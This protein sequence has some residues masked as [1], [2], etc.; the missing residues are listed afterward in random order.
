MDD[1]IKKGDVMSSIYGIGHSNKPIEVF[2][3]K[4][5]EYSIDTLVDVRT[6]PYSRF[7]P[8]FNKNR[9]S[10]SLEQAG[11]KYE[12]RG[13]NLGGL[14]ENINEHESICEL[15]ERA[16]KGE[17]I[18]VCCSEGSELKCHRHTKLM[19]Q[20]KAVGCGFVDIH[21]DKAKKSMQTQLSML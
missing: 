1:I 21:Y 8:Q 2:I 6:R 4:L 20:F 3:E 11:I 5:K 7:N 18:A 10:L 17:K 13:N 19:P 9:L 14:G 15:A 16:S 12:W